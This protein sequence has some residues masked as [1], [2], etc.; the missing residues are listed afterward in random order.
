M[1]LS[2]G[3]YF[4]KTYNN[5]YNSNNNLALQLIVAANCCKI[6]QQLAGVRDY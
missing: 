5:N 3:C 6:L 1:Y 4:R 2:I